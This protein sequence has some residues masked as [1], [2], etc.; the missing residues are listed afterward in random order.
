MQR[1]DLLKSYSGEVKVGV[2][3]WEVSELMSNCGADPGKGMV[4]MFV[5]TVMSTVSIMAMEIQVVCTM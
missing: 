5:G 2:I 3:S 1:F 4:Q